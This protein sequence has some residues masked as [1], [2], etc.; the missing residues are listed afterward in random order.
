[1]SVL[2]DISPLQRSRVER[3]RRNFGASGPAM[4]P[5]GVTIIHSGR[6]VLQ[7]NAAKIEQFP[8]NNFATQT[9]IGG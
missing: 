8:S 1:M 7:K 4:A 6:A 5:S 9:F 3:R 2:K